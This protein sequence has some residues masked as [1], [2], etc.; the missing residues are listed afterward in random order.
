M[1][2][3]VVGITAGIG[4][5]SYIVGITFDRPDIAAIG[6]II[7]IVISGAAVMGDGIQIEDGE[8]TVTTTDSER[9]GMTSIEDAEEL[10]SYG[11]NG[12]PAG[13]DFNVDGSM[14]FV[15]NTDTNAVNSFETTDYDMSLIA[16]N[17]SYTFLEDSSV[18]GIV[19]EPGGDRMIVTGSENENIYEY[20]LS[21]PY[22]VSTATF[23][24]AIDVS[25]QEVDPRAVRFNDDGTKLFMVG[26]DESSIHAYTLATPY[27]IS[28]ATTDQ[29]YNFSNQE[30]NPTGLE[31]MDDG[32]IMLM[33][34]ADEQKIYQYELSE[35]YDLDS[36]IY[37]GDAYDIEDGTTP[38]GLVSSANDFFVLLTEQQQEIIYQFDVSDEQEI[39]TEET[40]IEYS[41]ISED[42]EIPFDLLLLFLGI[43]M[44][45]HGIGK[46][47]EL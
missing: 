7:V 41:D 8:T 44:L 43:V 20:H 6:A 2:L 35:A 28:T 46:M 1:L 29:S 27:D 19:F 23:E 42:Y 16:E 33:T 22:N 12:T 3:E 34:G 30:S 36:V 38:H 13:I 47:E 37:N 39:T 45:F 24:H 14:M 11:F 25:A 17:E 15:I 32:E 31:F 5:V 40:T 4:I 10:T 21:D 9:V 18:S 26:P